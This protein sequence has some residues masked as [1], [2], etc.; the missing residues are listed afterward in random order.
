[1]EEN[2]TNIHLDFMK[3]QEAVKIE[4]KKFNKNKQL[5]YFKS[6]DLTGKGFTDEQIEVISN[7]FFWRGL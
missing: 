5:C 6:K 4:I 2:Y 1:M 3:Q 7:L